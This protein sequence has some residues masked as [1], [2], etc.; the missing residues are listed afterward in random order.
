MW[1]SISQLDWRWI[2]IQRSTR[3][4]HRPAQNLTATRKLSDEEKLPEGRLMAGAAA[5]TATAP[6]GTALPAA[7]GP[8][9][10]GDDYEGDECRICRLPAEADRPLR[11]P[12]ACRGSIRFVHD[13][14]QLRWLA[15][16]QQNRCEVCNRDISTRPLYVADAP[17]RLHV[18]ELMAGLPSKLMGLLLPLFFAVC[19]VW[20]FVIPLTTLWTWRLALATTFAHLH[21]CFNCALGYICTLGCTICCSSICALGSTPGYL[22][23]EPGVLVIWCLPGPSDIGC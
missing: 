22:E 13:D 15:A 17:A 21:P 16:R 23:W 18:S 11:R 7:D 12:C 5:A 2:S 6:P 3:T 4:L 1:K 20:E 19:V 10:D 9:Y 8:G 14:C